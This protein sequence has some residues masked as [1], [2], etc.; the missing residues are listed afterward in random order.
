MQFKLQKA[1]TGTAWSCC[2][3]ITTGHQGSRAQQAPSWTIL[4]SQLL[5]GG[6]HTCS[7]WIVISKHTSWLSKPNII[8]V[9]WR[10]T[11]LHSPFDL[12]TVQASSQEYFE[13]DLACPHKSIQVQTVVAGLASQYIPILIMIFL[14][15]SCSTI[16]D[17]EAVHRKV[18]FTE[19]RRYFLP[20]LHL[21]AMNLV[22]KGSESF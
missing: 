18:N 5:T 2:M 16:C 19:A 4:Y 1:C 9:P 7:L 17:S 11:Y 12:S 15:Y 13:S 21:K 22:E 8:T 6:Y 10:S 20:F 14:S 3:K